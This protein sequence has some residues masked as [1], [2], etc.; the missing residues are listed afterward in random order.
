[1]S[2]TSEK[3][4]TP[5]NWVRVH[6]ESFS[7]HAQAKAHKDGLDEGRAKHE[8][9]GKL[10]VAGRPY[11]A[12]D[13]RT[14]IVARRNGTYDVISYLT[15]EA[16]ED[17]RKLQAAEQKAVQA[18]QGTSEAQEKPVHGLKSKDRKKSPKRS[19]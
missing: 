1:M 12:T 17:T 9:E 11:R 13:G 10:A 19:R 7:T 8:R 4:L 14:K 6:L 16:Y 2:E 3:K 15:R 18:L 5:V